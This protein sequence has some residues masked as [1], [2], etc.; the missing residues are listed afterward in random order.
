MSRSGLEAGLLE[1]AGKFLALV[2]VAQ[3]RPELVARKPRKA[4]AN[5]IGLPL[6]L[7]LTPDLG[8]GRSQ[9]DIRDQERSIAIVRLLRCERRPRRGPPAGKPWLN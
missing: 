6:R 4:L 1:G 5:G 8:V 7:F 3:Q 2:R 9:D